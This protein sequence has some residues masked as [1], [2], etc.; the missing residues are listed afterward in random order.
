M[1]GLAAKEEA[2]SCCVGLKMCGIFLLDRV[3]AFMEGLF[4]EA[5][6]RASSAIAFGEVLKA[7]CPIFPLFSC[8]VS[9]FGL[10]S[11]TLIKQDHY[12]QNKVY[13][14]TTCKQIFSSPYYVLG[15]AV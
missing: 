12:V 3:N 9:I 13:R 14:C 4:L 8:R 6:F 5:L 10:L 11:G 2:A 1:R 15:H 7:F